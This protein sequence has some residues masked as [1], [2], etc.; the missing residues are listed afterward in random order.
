MNV[1]DYKAGD[2]IYLTN[3]FCE[4]YRIEDIPR[5][6]IKPTFFKRTFDS[7]FELYGYTIEYGSGG[8]DITLSGVDHKR[9][10]R[11]LKL[12]QIL[13]NNEV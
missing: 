8:H 1:E 2:T 10:Q 7:D 9:S 4:K 5:K 6:I 11:E 3:E 13:T 12:N